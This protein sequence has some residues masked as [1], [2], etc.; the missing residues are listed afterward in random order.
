MPQ[1]KLYSCCSHKTVSKSKFKEGRWG[2][3]VLCGINLGNGTL[4]FPA[5][6]CSQIEVLQCNAI[7]CTAKLKTAKCKNAKCTDNLTKSCCTKQC[8]ICI[9]RC[10]VL[11][12]WD[13][14]NSGELYGKVLVVPPVPNCILHLC[15]F[16]LL[17]CHHCI[18]MQRT[19]FFTTATVSCELKRIYTS[20][21]PEIPPIPLI[22]P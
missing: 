12:I 4:C 14:C 15:I 2:A 18:G 16:A 21:H 6:A 17:Q 10:L 20:P 13:R 3:G 8:L 11:S 9:R 5:S 19:A 7:M 1:W 22:A